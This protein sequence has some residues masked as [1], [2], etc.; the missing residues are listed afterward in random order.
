MLRSL[1]GQNL[2]GAV[3]VIGY[4]TIAKSGFLNP[5]MI[6]N[7]V[8]VITMSPPALSPIK[9]TFLGSMLNFSLQLLTSQT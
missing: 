2:D 3:H 7:V 9:I 5:A 1:D 4:I 8:N 6:A